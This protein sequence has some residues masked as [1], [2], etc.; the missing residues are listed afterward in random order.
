MILTG[1]RPINL[2]NLKWEYVQDDEIVYPASTVD[3]RG[4]MKNRAE[5]RI[6][7]TQ[8]IRIILNE[9]Q[10]WQD[11]AY[12]N[13]STEYVFLQPRDPMKAFARR[14]VFK[15]MR[16]YSPENCLHGEI[17]SGTVKGKDGAF[18]TMCRKFLKTN[19]IVQMRNKG[20]SRGDAEK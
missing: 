5:F 7:I 19:V 18:T 12:P 17:H 15:L 1:V 13:C 10:E 2:N 14:S 20:Y 8:K 6:P 16:E 11:A 3:R 4:A 9:Q